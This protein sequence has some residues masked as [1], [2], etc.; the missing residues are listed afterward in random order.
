MLQDST[1]FLVPLVDPASWSFADTVLALVASVVTIGGAGVGTWTWWQRRRKQRLLEAAFGG[2]L[3]TPEQIAN[4]TRYYVVPDCASVDP[5]NEAEQRRV[6]TTRQHLFEVVDQ[7]LA[8]EGQRHLLVLADSGMG[9]TSFC[10]N[11]YARN[12]T[13]PRRKR[14]RIK[15]IPLGLPDVEARIA[16]IER[17]NETVLF[18]DAFD[19]DTKA[20][21]DGH[22]ARLATLMTACQ[23]FQRVVITCRSQFFPS[24]EEVPK[25]V[26][27]IVRIGAVGLGQRRTMEFWKSYL[28][29]LRDQQIERFLK[30]RLRWYQ[31]SQKQKTRALI[32]RI[33]DMSARPMVLAYL[34][35]LIA[36]EAAPKTIMEI[37]DRIVEAWLDREAPYV[38][39]DAL[40][41]FSERFAV[42]LHLKREARGAERAHPHELAEL[43][44]TWNIPLENW[45]LTGRSLLNRDA[46]G[47]YKFAHRSFL[48]YF[49]VKQVL[50]GGVAI[51]SVTLTDQMNRFLRAKLFPEITSSDARSTRPLTEDVL[52]S[53]GITVDEARQDA[54]TALGRLKQ[55]MP[56]AVQDWF[57]TSV[58]VPAMRAGGKASERAALG[59]VLAVWGDPREPVL[60]PEAT[61]F[62]YVAKGPF[63]MGSSEGEGHSD[64][65]PQHTVDMSYDYWISR[66]PVTVAQ[67]QRFVEASGHQPGDADSLKG[68]AN[69]PVVWVSWHEALA[70]AQW[71]TERLR[72]GAAERLEH[73]VLIET[74]RM[75]WEGL[76]DGSLVVTLQS[77]AEWE[78]AAGDTTRAYPWGPSADPNRA[79]YKDT[80]WGTASAVGCFAQG[81]SPYGVEELSG[82]VWEWTRSVSA[83]YPYRAA[84]GREVLSASG[85][86]VL[87]GGAFNLF[88]YLVRVAFR[89]NLNP[90]DRFR[91]VGFR[92]VVLPSP[93]ISEPSGL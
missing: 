34:P 35:D 67:W 42:D 88:D 39:P 26:P 40:R 72:E 86:R 32:K 65:R 37:Y 56:L 23:E 68:H 28:L 70:Y 74:E 83:P 47:R 15:L 38:E 29:P 73:G 61:A 44:D 20:Q 75:R 1:S 54:A 36:S 10:L 51:A 59:N 55:H 66:F 92:V 33:P 8:S 90:L 79:N 27:G 14:R 46:Q 58:L 5:T 45:Q 9:K 43:R 4:S 2:E 31:W 84:D 30:K 19:E 17:K 57:R 11:Y 52:A 76:Y 81:Q 80:G 24:E 53:A 49:F 16:A 25:D 21:Q 13:R 18:L 69:H 7:L 63:T 91:Y 60:V 82:N 3:Y 89:L 87:R 6:V 64:E 71:L 48:E 85:T 22:R 12:R 77:E 41:N 93:L 78:K 50:A 62:C